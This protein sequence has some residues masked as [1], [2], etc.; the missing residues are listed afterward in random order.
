VDTIPTSK[1]TLN[2]LIENLCEIELRAD[3]MATVEATAFVAHENDKKV[4][5]YESYFQ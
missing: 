1:Q 3:K 2:F 4:K 5:F